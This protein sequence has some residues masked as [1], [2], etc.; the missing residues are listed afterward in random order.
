MQ[1]TVLA[2]ALHT[3]CEHLAHK[4]HNQQLLHKAAGRVHHVVVGHAW[5]AWMEFHLAKKEKKHKL[6]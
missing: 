1:N 3:W 2:K 5:N 4:Q 6:F